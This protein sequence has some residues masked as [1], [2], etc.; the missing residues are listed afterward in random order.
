MEFEK[1]VDIIAEKLP[2]IDKATIT[3]ETSFESLKVDSLDM[4]EIIM[5]IEETFNIT[6]D[7]EP[8]QL[9]TVNDLVEYIKNN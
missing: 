5:T 6:L 1:L 3:P 2:Q 8:D 9:K 7:V 4:V